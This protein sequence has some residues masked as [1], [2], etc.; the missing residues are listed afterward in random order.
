MAITKFTRDW[1]SNMLSAIKSNLGEFITHFWAPAVGSEEVGGGG[2]GG[3]WVTSYHF[4]PCSQSVYMFE[5][6]SNYSAVFS[7]L[8]H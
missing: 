3:G 2:G 1:N 7:D 8:M 4:T 5:F 6:F